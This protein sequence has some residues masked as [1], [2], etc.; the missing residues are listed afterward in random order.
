MVAR[1]HPGN[2][3]RVLFERTDGHIES[4]LAVD[5]ADARD[6]ALMFIGR[7]DELA[8]GDQLT[9]RKDWK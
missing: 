8:D 3:M 9:V 6:I 2:T 1:T 5:G 7:F 4:T